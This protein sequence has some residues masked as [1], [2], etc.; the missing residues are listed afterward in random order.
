MEKKKASALRQSFNVFLGLAVL[1]AVEYGISFIE[2]STI[3]LF[4]I[5]LLKAGLILNYFMHVGLLWSDG[6]KH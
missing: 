6:G 4:I 3:A 5:G 1:T 2:F